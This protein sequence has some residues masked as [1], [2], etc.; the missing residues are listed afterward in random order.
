[1]P[2]KS[3]IIKADI[4]TLSVDAFVNV[5]NNAELRNQ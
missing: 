5:A 3:G 1:M 2:A 4:P